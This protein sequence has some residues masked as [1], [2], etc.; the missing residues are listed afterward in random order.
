MYFSL[1]ISHLVSLFVLF[2]CILGSILDLSS[3]SRATAGP[4]PKLH[5]VIE[6]APEY[7]RILTYAL[8]IRLCRPCQTALGFRNS[9]RV[10][11]IM[12]MEPLQLRFTIT[13]FKASVWSLQPLIGH[14]ITQAVFTIERKTF[15][16]SESLS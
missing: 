12:A 13:L 11:A 9:C 1:H 10:R 6:C 4:Y 5:D 15:L 8:A 16:R 3:D 14:R 7:K 2:S